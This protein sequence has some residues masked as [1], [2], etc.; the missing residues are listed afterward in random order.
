[1]ALDQASMLEPLQ[2]TRLT[3]KV[4]RVGAQ[5]RRVNPSRAG[6][7]DCSTSRVYMHI[8]KEEI[9]IAGRSQGMRELE[10]EG[11][12]DLSPTVRHHPIGFDRV[13]LA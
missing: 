5:I 11:A 3:E 13:T 1:M 7:I 9:E 12:A 4:A 2:C 8:H 10:L 6:H